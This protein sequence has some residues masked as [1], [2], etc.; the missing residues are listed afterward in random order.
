MCV[1]VFACVCVYES[2]GQTK[3]QKQKQKTHGDKK[4]DPSNI[5]EEN[6]GKVKRN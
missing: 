4:L 3:K 5:R 6:G 2:D 1:Y